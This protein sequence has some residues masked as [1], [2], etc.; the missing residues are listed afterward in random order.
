MSSDCDNVYHSSCAKLDSNMIIVNNSTIKCCINNDV[1]N[2]IQ[3]NVILM[4]TLKQIADENNK[5]DIKII[6]F[7]FNQ[8]DLLIRDFL[9][10]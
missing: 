8:K 10:K 6:Q 9:I 2:N 4:D 1:Q 5:V 7:I 3:D